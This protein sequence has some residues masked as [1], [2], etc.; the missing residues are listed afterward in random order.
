VAVIAGAQLDTALRLGFGMLGV[1][2]A[3]GAINDLADATADGLA[4]P[5]KPIPGGLVSKR[6][7]VFVALSASA[8]GLAMAASVGA[9]ALIVGIVGL[10]DGLVYDLRLKRTPLAW[11]PFAGGVGLL[12]LYAWWGA[13]GVVP[14][15]LLSVVALA[16]C[17]GASLALANAYVDLEG[18]RDSGVP[19]VATAL[20]ARRTVLLNAALLVAVQVIAGATTFAA[21]GLTPLL[22]VEGA[23]CGLGWLGLAL[24]RWRVGLRRSLVWELQAIGVVV[25]G[26]AWLVVLDSAGVLRG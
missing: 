10:A 9:A 21:K 13:R 6:A 12:P 3:I 15:A 23:G 11:L 17:A 24:S 5:T 7:A 4:M 8:M 1:Q 22:L 16:V 25:L 26:A 19:S 2:F 20:G 14:P 18:D